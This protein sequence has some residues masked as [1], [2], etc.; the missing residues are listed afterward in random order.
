MVG[1]ESLTWVNAVDAV[2]FGKLAETEVYIYSW[3]FSLRNNSF[4]F[5]EFS[6]LNS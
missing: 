5:T 6:D 4:C 2:K 1:E 3:K